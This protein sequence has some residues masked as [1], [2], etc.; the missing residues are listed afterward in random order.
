MH[1]TAYIFAW[2]LSSFLVFLSVSALASGTDKDH[3]EKKG[4]ITE[5]PF[6]HRVLIENKGQFDGKIP[7]QSQP[8]LFGARCGTVD[9]YF[10]HQGLCFRKDNYKQLGEDEREIIEHRPG[11][12]RAQKLSKPEIQLLQAEW[13]G[14]NPMASITA[15]EIVPTSF[16]YPGHGPDQTIFAK[17]YKKIVYHDLY[18]HIDVEYVL[19]E[20]KKGLKYSL[21]VHPGADLA[22]VK[23]HYSGATQ[24]N[25]NGDLLVQAAFGE[26][27]DHSPQ[28]WYETNHKAVNVGFQLENGTLSFLL[29]KGYD[30]T[31]DLV[32]DPWTTDPAFT[33]YDGGY[34]LEYDKNGNVYVYGSWSPFQLEKFSPAGGPALWVYSA[35]ILSG[36]YYGDLATDETSGTTYLV[37]G[38]NTGS[39]GAQVLKISTGGAQTGL[40]PGNSALN[41]MWRVDYDACDKKLVIGCG[42]TSGQQQTAMLDTNMVTITGVNSINTVDNGYHDIC[43]LTIDPSGGFCYMA[44][45][46]SLVYGNNFDNMM[47]K[48]PIPALAPFVFLTADKHAFQEFTGLTY[49]DGSQSGYNGFNGMACSLNFLYTYNGDSINKFNKTTGAFIATVRTGTTMYTTGGLA[50]DICDHIYA[51]AGTVIKEFDVNLNLINTYPV[52]NTVFDVRLGVNNKLLATG[53]SFVQQ[54]DLAALTPLQLTTSSTPAGC[55]CSGTATAT[56]TLCGNPTT[57]QYSWNPGGQTTASV[58]NLCAGTYTVSVTPSCVLT[59][60]TGTVIVT[61][62]AG[63]LTLTNT[64]TNITCNGANNG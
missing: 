38:W 58:S 3:P 30:Q 61:G 1:K 19:P 60:I 28:A 11:S 59:P 9:L 26:L 43:L 42:G 57:V 23:L 63:A 4:W 51:G 48:V 35:T 45:T 62:S 56:T 53:V 8:I 24:L 6:E 33:G 5:H 16:N 20:G 50:V 27:C 25:A 44:T 49:V 47:F 18:P 37:E 2:L 31:R 40:F 13:I 10:G 34:D 12:R 14:S 46:H 7:G 36:M 21:I 17:A 54:I 64:Q 52:T 55:S 29:P 41:E 32:I 15:E 22:L 39:S